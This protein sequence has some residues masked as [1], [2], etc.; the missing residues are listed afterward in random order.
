MNIHDT[1]YEEIHNDNYKL[2]NGEF[3]PNI[4]EYFT[5]AKRYPNLHLMIEL[6]SDN[7]QEY[8]H[9]ALN[10]CVSKIQEYGMQNRITFISFS[11]SACIEFNRLYP[12]IDVFYLNG[13]KSPKELYELGID[14]MDYHYKYYYRHPEWIREAYQLG[15]K[16]AAWTVD[17]EN[18][19]N[20]LLSDGVEYLA[21][22]KP[23]VA[24]SVLENYRI[25]EF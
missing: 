18:D 1:L 12:S 11:L 9:R 19:M 6:K 7:N 23:S 22:N 2:S 21:T 24:L 17:D 20:I 25:I 10:A 14:G 5:I 16:V 15:L 3:L 8:E 13:D 4:D